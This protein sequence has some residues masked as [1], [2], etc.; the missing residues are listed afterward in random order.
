MF[1]ANLKVGRVAIW[2]MTRQVFII[3]L[4]YYLNKEIEPKFRLSHNMQRFYS[5]E[6]GEFF[7]YLDNLKDRLFQ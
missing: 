5:W 4:E 3:F 1:D 2:A 7:S 6:N